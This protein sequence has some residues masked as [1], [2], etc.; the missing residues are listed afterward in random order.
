MADA[1]QAV[2]VGAEPWTM[3]PCRDTSSMLLISDGYQYQDNT[4]VTLGHTRSMVYFR[5]NCKHND[6]G[7]PHR[8]EAAQ[9]G[10]C[11]YEMQYFSRSLGLY[12]EL[13]VAVKWASPGGWH[14][15]HGCVWGRGVGRGDKP[16][17][18]PRRVF[19]DR[20]VQLPWDLQCQRQEKSAPLQGI[21]HV[22]GGC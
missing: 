11:F 20:P 4:R 1:P 9:G 15:T 5:V 16:G 14:D 19:V 3:A 6:H 10:G 7:G 2:N 8:V 17:V 13:F 18:I 21:T 22:G 12:H